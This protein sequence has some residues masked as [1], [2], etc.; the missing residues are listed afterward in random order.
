MEAVGD[1]GSSTIELSTNGTFEARN[2]PTRVLDGFGGPLD[3][4]STADVTGT[5]QHN[6]PQPL[7]FTF[8]R[9][10]SSAKVIGVRAGYFRTVRSLEI[11]FAVNADK[12]IYVEFYKVND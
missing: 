9:T 12:S 1:E 4:S 5:W 2:L 7:T 3:W 11:S 10:S 6:E 8:D